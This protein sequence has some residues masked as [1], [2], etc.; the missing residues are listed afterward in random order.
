M[1]SNSNLKHLSLIGNVTILI[2]HS[3]S[4]SAFEFTIWSCLPWVLTIINKRYLTVLVGLLF[5][6]VGLVTSSG[7]VVDCNQLNT[8]RLSL[9]LQ[10]LLKRLSQELVLGLSIQGCCRNMVVQ[11]HRLCGKG[12]AHSV[13]QLRWLTDEKE[14]K[15]IISL[16]SFFEQKCELFAGSSF[17]NG[18]VCCFCWSLIGQKNPNSFSMFFKVLGLWL[19]INRLIVKIIVSWNKNA[20]ILSWYILWYIFTFTNYY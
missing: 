5:Q 15:L 19:T 7:E 8:P 13:V 12:S 11:H 14:N 3:N 1:E 17:L 9:P 20:E 2:Q 10:W 16:K 6:C 18:R 4:D